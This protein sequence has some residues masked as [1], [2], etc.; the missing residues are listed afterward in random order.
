[1]NEFWAKF[2]HFCRISQAVS[3][4]PGVSANKIEGA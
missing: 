1:M 3:F 2:L 4:S